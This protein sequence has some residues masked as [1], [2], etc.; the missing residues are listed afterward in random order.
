[1]A[2]ASTHV[3]RDSRVILKRAN[4]VAPPEPRAAMGA[5]APVRSAATASVSTRV[6]QEN[7]AI[8]RHASATAR[9]GHP[10]GIRAAAI[11]RPAATG[12]VST[13]AHLVSISTRGR[14][15]ARPV[16]Q[17]TPVV[18]T[19]ARPT[20][21]VV[22]TRSRACPAA[23]RKATVAV[24]FPVVEC[25]VASM[26]S[27]VARPTTPIIASHR[28]AIRANQASRSGA[29]SPNTCQPEGMARGVPVATETR[30]G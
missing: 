12:N 30:S 10:A 8:R 27:A 7:H 15:N 2:N 24:G 14:V 13:P 11:P 19:A 6:H 17:A 22:R 26:S 16:N 9:Q 18:H 23:T 5:A 1:M 29:Q 28:P 3:H 25:A 21:S 4:A 20:R